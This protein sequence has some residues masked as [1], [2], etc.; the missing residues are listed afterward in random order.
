[1]NFKKVMSTLMATV[2]V[3]I[4]SFINAAEVEVS[5]KDELVEAIKVSGNEIKLLKD[6]DVDTILTINDGQS[7][8][9][10]LNG[11]DINFTT[12]NKYIALRHGNLNITG[13]GSIV[14]KQPYLSPV[15]MK[16][17]N[18]ASASNYTTLTV[19]KNVT[20]TGWAGVMIDK[21]SSTFA[22]AYGLTLNVYGTLNGVDDISGAQGASIYFNGSIKHKTNYP[23]INIDGAS[24]VSENGGSIY[25][26]GYAKWNI[27]NSTITGSGFG[28]GT[29]SGI[30]DIKN[31]TITA[32]GE[33]TA[34][35]YNGNG[36][37]VTGSAFQVESN[38]GYAGDITITVEDSKLESKNGNAFYHYYA[39][40][41]EGET[42]TN[43]LL[44]FKTINSEYNG[45]M[46]LVDKDNFTI[47]GGKFSVDVSSYLKDTY[48]V[49]KKGN[50]YV[51][52]NYETDVVN[53][54]KLTIKA[55][56]KEVTDFI[57]PGST[58]TLNLGLN[59]NTYIK[60]IKV[61]KINDE[62]TIVEVTNN[63]F[64]MPEYGVKIVIKTE[65]CSNKNGNIVEL[66]S[67]PRVDSSVVLDE[68]TKE[69]MTRE[70]EN[71]TGIVGLIDISKLEASEDDLIEIEYDITLTKYDMENNTLSFVIKPYYLVNNE[72]IGVVPNEAIK[73]KVKVN[74][75]VPSSIKDTH[76]KVKHYDGEKLID[77]KEYEIKTGKDGNKYVTIETDSF[78]RFELNFYTPVNNPQTGDNVIYYIM[79]S[80]ISVLTISAVVIVK[81]HF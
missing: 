5:T 75:P 51:V 21:Y 26:A 67:L 50:M 17:A 66:F 23:I 78:S 13:E 18:S 10:N 47:E 73:G 76:V 32:T 1:M 63:S 40:A 71:E 72:E 11:H 48:S 54:E 3:L 16:G 61:T 38:D 6:I 34:G 12:A 20:L 62:N 37:G 53:N 4:P 29:K 8:T 80:I 27:K 28:I 39:P 79:A 41:T 25:A 9:L 24:L 15:V 49:T 65:E 30:F 55:D 36:I 35:V 69:E 68:E 56:G 19:G 45:G 58:V 46:E 33:K 14:E 7:L 59:E 44:S 70:I 77:E 57:K 42:V 60:E 52:N 74:V 64:V 81:K 31:T 2:L 22:T 43:S